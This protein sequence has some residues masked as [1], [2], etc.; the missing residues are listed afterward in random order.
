MRAA[1]IT[2]VLAVGCASSSAP[3]P[4]LEGLALTSVAPGEIIPGT[5]VAVAGGSFVDSQ[6]GAGTLHLVGSAG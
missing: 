6:W 2:V 1:A 3:D 5:K 4:G